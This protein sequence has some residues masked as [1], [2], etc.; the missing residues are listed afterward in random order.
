MSK[1]NLRGKKRQS[2]AVR[3]RSSSSRRS[4]VHMH[5]VFGKTVNKKSF[6]APANLKVSMER[7]KKVLCG[8]LMKLHARN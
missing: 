8:K 7:W 1:P 5:G 3:R 6:H 2:T 4:S